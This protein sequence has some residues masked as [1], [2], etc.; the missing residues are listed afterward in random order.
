MMELRRSARGDERGAVAVIVALVAVVLF[1]AAALAVDFS[2]LAMERQKLHDH[3]DSAAHA[4][5]YKLPDKPSE[6]ISDALAIATAQDSSLTPSADLFCVIASDGATTPGP[7]SSQVPAVCNPGSGGPGT[8]AKYPLM[9]C[10]A[11]ICAIPCA[12]TGRCN[13][14]TVSDAKNVNYAFAPIMGINQGNTGS[15]ASS[16][17]KGGC[18]AASPNPLDVAIVADRTGSMSDTDRNEMVAGIKSMLEKMTPS[19]QFVSFGTIGPTKQSPGTCLTTPVAG[20]L[21]NKLITTTSS[22]SSENK[23]LYKWMALPFSK[24]YLG[25]DGKVNTTSNLIKALNCLDSSSTGTHLAAP[26]KA[27]ARYLKN[28]DGSN[29]DALTAANPRL[30]T[31]RKVIIFETDGQPNED[32]NDATVDLELSSSDPNYPGS[33]TV[34]TACDRLNAVADKA[35]AAGILIITVAYNL[36]QSVNCSS[37]PKLSV[38]QS[39][40]RAAS[41]DSSGNASDVDGDCKNS[42]DRATENGDGD[43]FFCAAS[44]DNMSSIFVSALNA[45]TTGIRLFQMP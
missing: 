25:T 4:G 33:P 9:R 21:T 19:L 24:D 34:S 39:L 43:F 20:K 17:C 37:S 28:K 44:G 18:G 12:T 14:I 42:T 2:S 41:V 7:V 15:V 11:S 8:K 13:A 38:A 23:Q 22:K 26:M 45:V 3:I 32:I 16:A 10:N 36:D 35:K 5:A 30:G 1:S 27:A 31:I 40:A 6:A 29:I